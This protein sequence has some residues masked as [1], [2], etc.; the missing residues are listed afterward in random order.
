MKSLIDYVTTFSERGACKCG[1]CCDVPDKPEEHQPSGHTA[2]TMFFE[3]SAKDG[4]DADTLRQLVSENTKGEFCDVT[5]LDGKEH[6]YMEIGGWIGD[7]GL[8]LMLMGLG[9]VLGLWK[10][11]TPKSMLGDLIPKE[12]Q[13]QMAGQ[14]MV[15]IQA[16]S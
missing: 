10:L 8:A 11:L 9:S 6:N 4:A 2:D 7:Q 13:M 1:R 12:L 15:A 5:L 14:G 16:K 3:V